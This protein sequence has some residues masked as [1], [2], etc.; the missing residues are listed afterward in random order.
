M[1]KICKWSINIKQMYSIYFLG[2]PIVTL[3][4]TSVEAIR[5]IDTPIPCFVDA[6]QN[7]TAISWNITLASTTLVYSG[8]ATGKYEAVS[9]SIP[10]L[11]I[12][13]PVFEDM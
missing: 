6:Y 4:Q 3:S 13:T 2:R 5:N 1:W 11:T 8:A 7:A 9:P 12:K 10:Y